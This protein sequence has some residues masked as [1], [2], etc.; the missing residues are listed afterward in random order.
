M[1][2]EKKLGLF[3]ILFIEVLVVF[4]MYD[5]A[6]AS[7]GSSPIIELDGSFDDWQSIEG[8]E[9]NLNNMEEAKLLWQEEYIYLYIREKEQ[10]NGCFTW[11]EYFE[12]V[13]NEGIQTPFRAYIADWNTSVKPLTIV[14]ITGAEGVTATIEN[15][16][17]Y[18]M[19]FPVS[20]L[21]DSITSVELKWKIWNSSDTII[22]LTKT[23]PDS[24]IVPSSTPSS[25]PPVTSTELPTSTPTVNSPTELP[26]QTPSS[27]DIMIDGYFDDWN[28]I[29]SGELKKEKYVSKC[30]LY[31]SGNE[32][33]CHIK[34]DSRY[35]AQM[36][37]NAY[38]LY[39]NDKSIQMSTHFCTSDYSIDWDADSQIYSM[40]VGITEN[41][42]MFY[43]EYPKYY[44][45]KAAFRCY[46]KNHTTGDELE[47]AVSLEV[48]SKIT[49]IPVDSITKV[50]IRGLNGIGTGN[51]T[52][53]GSSTGAV[54]GVT[55]C[56]CTVLGIQ[57]IKRRRA[58]EIKRQ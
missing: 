18:E 56:I 53:S 50:E 49:G 57:Y 16:W 36:P 26:T 10:I 34:M 54:I 3:I 4:Y 39:V 11:N 20:S 1:N 24:T 14:G 5:I 51:I 8:V 12:F 33:Y 28:Q 7:N 32:V 23:E 48:L 9:L 42:G 2:K 13:T 29:P 47:F 22:T 52:T 55:L 15:A 38:V 27:T 25:E 45:G 19:R 31:L 17:C 40:P 37:L 44:M 58:K 21:G 41:L 46:H 30:A 35:H 6:D 43:D